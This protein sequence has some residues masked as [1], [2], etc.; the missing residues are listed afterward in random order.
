MVISVRLHCAIVVILVNN[1]GFFSADTLAALPS[2]NSHCFLMEIVIFLSFCLL[3]YLLSALS[4]YFSPACVCF[5][6]R[7]LLLLV[8]YMCILEVILRLFS[9]YLI[10]SC[11]CNFI[12]PN[13]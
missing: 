12:F 7:E 4:P 13:W 6:I 5:E 10:A 11:T 3:G 9:F 2:L 1:A 8:T